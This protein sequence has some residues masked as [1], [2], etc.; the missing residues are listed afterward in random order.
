MNAMLAWIGLGQERCRLC[1]N[2]G[3]GLPIGIGRFLAKIRNLPFLVSAGSIGV[4]L[5]AIAYHFQ[6]AQNCLDDF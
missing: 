5:F 3:D 6:I 4:I 1:A 2:E